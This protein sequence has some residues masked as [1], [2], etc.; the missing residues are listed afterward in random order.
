GLATTKDLVMLIDN[1][2]QGDWYQ[3]QA[4][5]PSNKADDAQNPDLFQDKAP[6]KD[7]VPGKGTWWP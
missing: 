1:V 4:Q 6:A 3:D 2:A 5:S 7:M